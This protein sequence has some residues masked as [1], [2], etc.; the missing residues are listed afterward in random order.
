MIVFA[1]G[2]VTPP[3]ASEVRAQRFEAV[4]TGGSVVDAGGA[5][6]AGGTAGVNGPFAIGNSSFEFT[7][8]GADPAATLGFLVLGVP[9]GQISCGACQL[10]SPIAGF[11]QTVAAGTA[12][13]SFPLAC[14]PSLLGGTIQC[15]W[16]LVTP[17]ARPCS[18]VPGASFSNRLDATFGL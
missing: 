10:T 14:S 15:Q 1:S 12:T 18:L 9:A 5:C 3:F 13:Q 2:D 8:T 7:L 6:G 16:W 11:V 4:G 17:A